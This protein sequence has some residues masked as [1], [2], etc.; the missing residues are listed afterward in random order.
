MVGEAVEYIVGGTGPKLKAFP[1]QEKALDETPNHGYT[2]H[3][4]ENRKIR[5][6]W[7][8]QIAGEDMPINKW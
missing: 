8:E 3:P 2:H 6:N 7:T 1:Q 5:S 4:G